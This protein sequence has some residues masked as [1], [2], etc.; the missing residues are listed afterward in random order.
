MAVISTQ[1]MAA[2]REFD[3][4]L[5]RIY[6]EKYLQ[7]GV[8]HDMNRLKTIYDKYSD[9]RGGE[10]CG[11][12]GRWLQRLAAWYCITD[13]MGTVPTAA[14]ETIEAV[15]QQGETVRETIKKRAGRPKKA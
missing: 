10:C 8:P 14:V 9:G 11:A 4:R 6:Q 2:L 3:A 1:D 13:K 5:K 15:Y 12:S 7:G